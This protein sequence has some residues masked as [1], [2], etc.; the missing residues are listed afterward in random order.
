L[1]RP[2]FWFWGKREEKRKAEEGEE[3]VEKSGSP[4]PG[5]LPSDPPT[6]EREEDKN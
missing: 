4:H 5:P 3:D 2:F 1:G 6:W